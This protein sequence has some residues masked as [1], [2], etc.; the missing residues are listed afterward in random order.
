MDDLRKVGVPE[1][2]LEKLADA[3]AFRSIDLDRR[4]ALWEVSTKDRNIVLYE[5]L[6]SR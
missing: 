5:G 2:A 3:D 1:S 4:Q 6:A